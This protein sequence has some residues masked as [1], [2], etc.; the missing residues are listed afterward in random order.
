MLL[1]GAASPSDW[2]SFRGDPGQ[3]G[4]AGGSLPASLELLWSFQTEGGA[5]ASSPVV[6]ADHVF[7]GNDDGR[8][9]AVDV[10]SGEPAW[11]LRTD[12]IIE[13]PPMVHDGVVY[14]GSSDGFLYAADASTGELR[15]KSPTGD[16][17]LG[18]ASWVPGDADP[19]AGGKAGR[20]LVGSYDNRLYCFDAAT[21]EQLW[22]YETDNYINGT[23]AI[24][25]GRVVFGGCD[26]ALHV[27]SASTGEGLQK[28]ALRDDC[29]IAGS[30]ALVDG[31]AYFGHYGNAFVCI[32]LGGV[33]GAAGIERPAAGTI[34]WEYTNPREGFFSAPAVGSDRVVFGGRDRQVHCVRRDSGEALWTFRTRRK[35]DS[36]PV[37]CG[38]KVVCASGDG[39]L[40]V[41]SLEDGEQLWSYE[42]G[43]SIFSS[44]ALAGGRVFVGAND[45][46]MY[47]FGAGQ[48]PVEEESADG[49]V[50]GGDGE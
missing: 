19:G 30:V 46:R 24:D 32:E 40:Y 28:V 8:L 4:V 36:S 11:E 17:I 44:P 29:H 14:V 41:L 12:D 13:A 21:G 16:K 1:A 48:D 23:P 20:V 7:F 45:G 3:S 2:T 35:V 39:R 9:Y 27:V 38:D 26:A 37:I 10:E 5:I 43:E 18:G 47:A 33:A 6:A 34:V 42:I 15:W 25:A 31:R 50:N 22:A 49:T